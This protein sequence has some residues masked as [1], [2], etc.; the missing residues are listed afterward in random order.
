M[1]KNTNKNVLLAIASVLLA[2]VLIFGAQ[3]GLIDTNS[4]VIAGPVGVIYAIVRKVVES[5]SKGWKTYVS[6]GGLV[7]CTVL[8]FVGIPVPQV[9]IDIL[10]GFGAFGLGDALGKSR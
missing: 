8:N 6:A 10:T 9:V 2:T 1:K 7:L 5:K 3:A 4:T